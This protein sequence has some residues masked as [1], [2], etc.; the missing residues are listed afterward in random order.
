MSL[1]DV[2][3]R[4]VQ[5]WTAEGIPLLPPASE[6]SIRSVFDRR[7]QRPSA[8]VIALYSTVG[9]F[10]DYADDKYM[11]SFWS[12]E[13]VGSESVSQPPGIIFSDAIIQAHVY[14]FRYED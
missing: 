8:D 6:A 5:A 4:A 11:W 12:L 7:R 3:A 10:K 1:T 9:G 13:R 2:I 14:R